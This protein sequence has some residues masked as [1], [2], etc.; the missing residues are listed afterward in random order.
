MVGRFLSY[1]LMAGWVT[2]ERKQLSSQSGRAKRRWK[3]E[4]RNQKSEGGAGF[5]DTGGGTGFSGDADA[6]HAECEAMS[7]SGGGPGRAALG[8][9]D[10]IPNPNDVARARAD[11]RAEWPAV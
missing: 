6:I 7:G 1:P 10:R 2:Y 8:D 4:I 9:G 5:P 3:S 11:D